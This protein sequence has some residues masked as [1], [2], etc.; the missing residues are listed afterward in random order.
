MNLGSTGYL[1]RFLL[2]AD[3]PLEGFPV[4][5]PAEPAKMGVATMPVPII[6]QTNSPAAQ[7]PARGANDCAACAAWRRPNL[8]M[9]LFN[10]P[11]F[12]SESYPRP[13]K[14]SACLA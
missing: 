6:P 14:H 5:Y 11:R 1:L 10:K 13:S 2:Q 9:Q 8:A 12:S 3:G 4:A 7:R